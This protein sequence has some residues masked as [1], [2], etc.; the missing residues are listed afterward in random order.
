[1]TVGGLLLFGGRRFVL[2][3]LAVPSMAL[4]RLQAELVGALA[5][6]VDAHGTFAA[7]RWTPHITLAKRMTADEVGVA[8]QVLGEV[9]TLAGSLT[10]A[11]RWDIVAKQEERITPPDSS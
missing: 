9:P 1:V 8:L 7:G 6:P 11:R 10:A 3:R 2:A 5:A 4:L